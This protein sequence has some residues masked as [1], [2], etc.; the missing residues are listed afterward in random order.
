ML[1]VGRGWVMGWGD[2]SHTVDPA[3]PPKARVF[4][5]RGGPLYRRG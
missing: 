3:H 4:L 2:G 5:A 1:G